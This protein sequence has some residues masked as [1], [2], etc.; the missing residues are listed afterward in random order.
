VGREFWRNIN[1]ARE[2]NR[3]VCPSSFARQRIHERF[4]TI[5]ISVAPRKPLKPTDNLTA[6]S[7]VIGC[8]PSHPMK[9]GRKMPNFLSSTWPVNTNFSYSPVLIPV[10]QTWLA[11]VQAM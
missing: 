6:P 2:A 11:L 7:I 8:P 9:S 5:S 3:Q 4:C 1:G 10:I